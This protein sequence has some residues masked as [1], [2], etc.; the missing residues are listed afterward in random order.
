MEQDAPIVLYEATDGTITLAVRLE[1]ESVWLTQAQMA[2][3]FQ[4][5]RT[6]IGRHIQNIYR[7]GELERE[8]TCAKFAHLG[9]IAKQQY[10]TTLY[11]LDVIISVGY[12]VKSLRGVQ[13]RQWATK[14]L[15]QDLSRALLLPKGEKE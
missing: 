7:E 13:F 5:D 15:T 8:S 2:K 1:G 4:K 14:L 12:R 6:V 3:L 9:Q 10:E 11:N